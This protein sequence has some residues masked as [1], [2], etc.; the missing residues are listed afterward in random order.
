MLLMIS[1]RAASDCSAVVPGAV[2]GIR[3]AAVT[4]MAVVLAFLHGAVLD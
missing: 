3:I 2:P 1:S 4:A